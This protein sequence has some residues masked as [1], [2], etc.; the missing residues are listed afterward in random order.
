V[1]WY[2]SRKETG[3]KKKKDERI[4]TVDTFYILTPTDQAA[5]ESYYLPLWGGSD[6]TNIGVVITIIKSIKTYHE[7]NRIKEWRI[8]T[9]H[10]G[11]SC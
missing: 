10:V 3:K 5:F 2:G 4:K 6:N 8:M 1:F 9:M 7:C 11:T